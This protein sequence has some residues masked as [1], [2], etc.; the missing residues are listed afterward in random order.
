MEVRKAIDDL[1]FSLETIISEDEL[2]R[3]ITDRL[4][5][6]RQCFPSHR[7]LFAPTDIDF[8]KSLT[9]VSNHL[10]AFIELKEELASV[11]SLRE[12]TEIVGRL[13]QIKDALHP[14]A[15]AKRVRKEIR[16]LNERLPA[17]REN[18]EA[19]RKCRLNARIQDL[20]QT[21]RRCR[22]HHPMVIREGQDGYFWGCSR[23]PFCRATI[24]LTAEESDLLSC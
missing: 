12:Y 20:E 9:P 23:Y 7:L 22:R 19:Q 2:H 16:E 18:D 6:L 1:R 14:V 3:V 5:A 17:I 11:D 8:L 13:T 10:R 24:Q 4:S 21:P 15:V